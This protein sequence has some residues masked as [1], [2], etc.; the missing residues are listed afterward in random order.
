MLMKV[1][2]RLL[3]ATAAVVCCFLLYRLAKGYFYNDQRSGRFIGRRWGG[4]RKDV[5]YTR[6]PEGGAYEDE[7]DGYRDSD[8]F[9]H[10]LPSPSHPLLNRPLPDKPLPPLPE[11]D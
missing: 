9:D 1:A 11:G 7:Q 8:T 4:G 2:A 5:L 6:L 10:P 3:A